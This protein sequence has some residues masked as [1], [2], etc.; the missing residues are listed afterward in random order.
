MTVSRG[1]LFKAINNI[2]GRKGMS[3]K[4]SEDLC[5]FILSFFGYE[6]YII[7]PC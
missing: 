3:K 5:D 7:L 6:D 1:E 4:D 2:Y